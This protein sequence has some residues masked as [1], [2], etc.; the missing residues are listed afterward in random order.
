MR[1]LRPPP[2]ISFSR[3]S[4][5]NPAERLGYQKDG[6]ADIRKHRWYQGFDWEGLDRQ[7]LSP[8]IQ[9]KVRSASDASN[10]DSYPRDEEVP[11]D[12]LSGWDEQF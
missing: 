9:V 8:P 11:P 7:T 4:R 6:V 2:G 1:V 3:P 5:E 10:F 12:E